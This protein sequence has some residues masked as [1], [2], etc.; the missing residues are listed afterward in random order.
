MVLCLFNINI[1]LFKNV[2]Q[3]AVRIIINRE[4][5]YIY[6]LPSAKGREFDSRSN[7]AILITK[8]LSMTSKRIRQA[9][10]KILC[11]L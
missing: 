4:G 2:V 7:R 9:G 8:S 5:L 3:F 6:D 11:Y 10:T 1:F